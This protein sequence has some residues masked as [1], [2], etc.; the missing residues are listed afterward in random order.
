MDFLNKLGVI[1]FGITICALYLLG[2]KDAWAHIIFLFSY[3]IQ[4][5]IFYKTKQWFLIAQMGVLFV[6]S[7]VNYFRWTIGG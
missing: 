5:Y 6:F 4:I 3:S 2:S 7:I 1:S